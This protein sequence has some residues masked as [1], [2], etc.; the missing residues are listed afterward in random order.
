[1]LPLRAQR[2][3]RLNRSLFD[4]FFNPFP[5]FETSSNPVNEGF[6]V[7]VKEEDASY[8]LEAELPGIEQDKIELAVEQGTLHISASLEREEKKEDGGYLYAERRVG[9][10]KRSFS[11]EGIDEKAITAA[12]KDGILRVTLP[13][14]QGEERPGRRQIEIGE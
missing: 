14:L 9:S 12:Y 6:R 7:D 8:L 2:G 3:L 4:P 13:K 5:F 1:M 10:F 11:L